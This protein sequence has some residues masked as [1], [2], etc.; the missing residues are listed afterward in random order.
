MIG[1]ARNSNLYLLEYLLSYPVFV[2]LRKF[3]F[4]TNILSVD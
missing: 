4:L 1:L 3:D 2:T